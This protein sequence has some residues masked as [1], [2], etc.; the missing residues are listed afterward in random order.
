MHLWHGYAT[1][2]QWTPAN[3]TNIPVGG[4]FPPIALKNE[5]YA[6]P[7]GGTVI[8]NFHW[9]QIYSSLINMLIKSLKWNLAPYLTSIWDKIC[10]CVRLWHWSV[11]NVVNPKFFCLF[12]INQ[13]VI[14]P[15]SAFNSHISQ[16][17]Y[18]PQPPNSVLS[19]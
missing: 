18:L 10:I 6:L 11:W 17:T 14:D 7:I 12:F 1:V 3:R 2:K 16:K 4:A 9:S 13:L 15:G 19:N 8:C 5:H